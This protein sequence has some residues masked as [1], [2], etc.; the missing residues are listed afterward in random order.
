MAEN[1]DDL[2]KQIAQLKK[3]IKNL[4]GD[5]FTDMD[6]AIKSFGG[7]VEGARKVIVDM[8][9]DVAD[10]R[11]TF[12]TI[13]TTLRN[14]V[15]DLKGT[16]DYVKETTKSF[17]KLDKLSDEGYLSYNDPYI[18]IND[19]KITSDK[20]NSLLDYEKINKFSNI[21]NI[22]NILEKDHL[23]KECIKYRRTKIHFISIFLVGFIMYLL[24]S[25]FHLNKEYIV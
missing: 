14:I 1:F 16:P 2:K 12:G 9:K 25:L 13:S 24:F 15:A 4:G 20:I 7:G 3:E 18:K 11:D 8:K 23:P 17:D 21:S 22:Q 10:L 5:T 6:A 19:S